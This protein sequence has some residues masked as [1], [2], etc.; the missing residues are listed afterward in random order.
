MDEVPSD[1]E[2]PDLFM[3]LLHKMDSWQWGAGQ[4]LGIGFA[5][6]A[7][8]TQLTTPNQVLLL[9]VCNMQGSRVLMQM[10]SAGEL[11]SEG[12]ELAALMNRESGRRSPRWE[13]LG[14]KARSG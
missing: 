12:L 7:L 2:R 4:A 8:T 14:Q 5:P 6:A 1:W 13:L 3:Q 9:V 11:G 10:M